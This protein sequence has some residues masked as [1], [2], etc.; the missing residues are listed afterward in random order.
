[1]DEHFLF[2]VPPEQIKHDRLQFTEDEAHHITKVLRKQPGDIVQATDGVGNTMDVR[3]IVVDKKKVAG[4][5]VATY[6]TPAEPDRILAMGVIRQR[7]RLEFAIEKAVE[8]GVTKIV[9][10][11]SEH[12]GRMEIKPRRIDKTI[13]SAIKQSRR[14][15]LPAWEERASFYDVL[16]DYR[17]SRE[18]VMAHPDV[19]GTYE[20][21]ADDTPML[22]LVG[23]EGGFSPKEVEQ[24]V[25]SGVKVVSLG[26]KRLR[27][28]TAVCA[29]LTLANL[30]R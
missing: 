2:Y 15:W 27:T 30:G 10:V 23:P 4:E 24:A 17:E 22:L 3:L 5:V 9:L 21:K 19:E 29:M 6:N 12:A 7:E 13:V 14:P 26:Q 28:E 18:V 16:A 25:A 20:W 11:H 1:M 8:L